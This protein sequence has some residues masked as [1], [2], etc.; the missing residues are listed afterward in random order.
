MRAFKPGAFELALR[1]GCP[2]LPIVIEG[3]ADALPKRGFVLRGRHPLRI[4]VLEPVR[5]ADF[6]GQ[7]AEALS[8]HVRAQ[9]ASHLK[10][11]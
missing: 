2:V 1:N 4:T 11:S 9:I 5:V 8:D 6:A 3:T 10:E 7:D